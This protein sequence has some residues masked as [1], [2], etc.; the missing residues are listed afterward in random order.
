MGSGSAVVDTSDETTSGESTSRDLL[1]YIL[2]FSTCITG[3]GRI[4]GWY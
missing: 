1:T 4:L 2:T 3:V